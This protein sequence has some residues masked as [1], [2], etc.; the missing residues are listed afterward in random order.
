MTL[1]DKERMTMADI[2]Q[3]QNEENDLM[4]ELA[5]IDAQIRQLEGSETSLNATPDSNMSKLEQIPT[6][7]MRSIN[8]AKSKNKDKKS[9]W[10]N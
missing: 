8:I 3:K 2:V 4:L 7:L 9:K 1:S 6:A 10:D 5:Q